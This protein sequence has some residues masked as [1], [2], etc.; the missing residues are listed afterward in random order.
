MIFFHLFYEKENT[1]RQGVLH[2]SKVY[3]QKILWF[4]YIQYESLY[5]LILYGLA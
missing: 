1:I 2:P 5:K 3:F 4:I